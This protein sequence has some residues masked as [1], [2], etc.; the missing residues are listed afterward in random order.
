MINID[1]SNITI[2]NERYSGDRGAFDI[3]PDGRPFHTFRTQT[4][5]ADGDN[6]TFRSCRFENL[7]KPD[8][9]QAI[10]L[11]LDGDNITCED[12]EIYGWQDT[13]FL[14]PLPPKEYEKDGFIG[15]KEHTPRTP[16]K[17]YFRN[18]L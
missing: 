16:R 11:Y 13:L 14:A 3:H 12:C 10:A 4:V 6:I 2:E 17:F 1:K 15:P 5:L 8:R 18:C 7:A 9:G